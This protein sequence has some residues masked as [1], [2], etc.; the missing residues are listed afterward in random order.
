[1]AF[2]FDSTIGSTTSN[3]Y[4]SVSAAEDYFSGKFG[5]D[6]WLDFSEPD[7]QKL[8]VTSTRLLDTNVYSGKK[9]SSSQSLEW[10]RSGIYNRDGIVYAS[11]SL[12]AQLL[13][14][15]CELAFWLW[16]EEDRFLSDD[17]MLQVDSYK[18]GPLD[19]KFSSNVN[20]L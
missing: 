15:T 5:S 12:P 19:V 20:V 11:N 6:E 9:T 18:V 1:M 14:A 8:L 17:Q 10:P 3:S 13:A 2:L 4:L 16:T 7:K